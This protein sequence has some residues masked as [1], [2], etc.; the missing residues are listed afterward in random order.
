MPSFTRQQMNRGDNQR[1]PIDWSCLR[2]PREQLTGP[3][4]PTDAV[5]LRVERP[6]I[7]RAWNGWNVESTPEGSTDHVIVGPEPRTVLQIR[8]DKD[9]EVNGVHVRFFDPPLGFRAEI[10]VCVQEWPVGLRDVP[11]IPCTGGKLIIG[12]RNF[13]ASRKITPLVMERKEHGP[14]RKLSRIWGW[15]RRRVIRYSEYCI[16][17]ELRVVNS[18]HFGPPV[19]EWPHDYWKWVGSLK[20]FYGKQCLGIVVIANLPCPCKVTLSGR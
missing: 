7:A 4:R 17:A 20:C 11:I 10:G 18:K 15:M 16:G 9:T 5:K 19:V 2:V 1:A 3:L 12:R 14:R 8:A 6:K 13:P